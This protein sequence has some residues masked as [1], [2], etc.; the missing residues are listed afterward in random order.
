MPWENRLLTPERQQPPKVNITHPCP[1]LCRFAFAAAFFVVGLLIYYGGQKLL[2]V[3]P[4]DWSAPHWTGK[5]VMLLVVGLLVG[6]VAGLLAFGGCIMV[7]VRSFLL[8]ELL[9][10]LWQFVFNG[11]FAWFVLIGIAMSASAGKENA[12]AIVIH[13][14]AEK[15]TLV[16]I[17]LGCLISTIQGFVFFLAPLVRLRLVPYLVFCMGVALAAARWD[18]HIFGIVGRGWIVAGILHP[19]ALLL[20]APPMIQRDRQQRRLV[21]Q[22]R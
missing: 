19:L 15:A 2:H 1:G 17:G 11:S 8:N 14:G 16:A 18:Y 6:G 22:D 12:K 21:M 3:P 13:Y 20:L 4:I 9:T 7:P 5:H 10:V